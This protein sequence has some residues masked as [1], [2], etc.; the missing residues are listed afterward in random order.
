MTTWRKNE[1]TAARRR[2]HL[3]IFKSDGTP[4]PRGTDFVALGIV[5]VGGANLPDLD[6]A[7][8]TMTNQRIGLVVADDAVEGVGTNT[9]TLTAH[10]LET[11]DGPIRFTT[12]GTLPTGMST[13]TDYWVVKSDADTISLATTLAHAYADTL[14]SITAS[15]G[16][17]THT[18]SDT[19]TTQRGVDGRFVYEATQTET[20]H[21]AAEMSIVVD[22]GTSGDYALKDGA[23]GSAYVTMDANA[24]ILNTVVTDDGKTLGDVI[25]FLYWVD[26]AGEIDRDPATGAITIWNQTHTKQIAT[27]TVNA[28]GRG[29]ITIN[30]DLS[31]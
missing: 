1:P 6:T 18:L 17:G 23:G 26:G 28:D 25:R 20:N 8:G 30:A 2:C 29:T 9:L 10:G 27:M 19:A 7:T 21:D 12:T 15:S 5:Y 24:A 4:A 14:V 16:S 22:S 31:A 3:Q 13:A 11:G